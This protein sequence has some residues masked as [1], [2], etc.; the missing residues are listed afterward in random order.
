MKRAIVLAASLLAASCGSSTST[1]PTSTAT[2]T[3][4]TYT[5]TGIVTSTTTGAAIVGASVTVAGGAN[6]G[7]TTTTD[8]GGNYSLAGLAASVFTVDVSATDY[9]PVAD[10]VTLTANQT[11]NVPLSPTPLF[12]MRGEGNATFNMPTAVSKVHITGAYLGVTSSFVVTIGGKVVV[13]DLV[14]SQWTP[15][16]SDGTYATTGGTVAI[17]NSTDVTWTFTEVR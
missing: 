8:S 7:L 10:P 2:T 6:P 1:T 16:V 14:G 4:T 12:V 17:T 3:T 9:N 5:L 15:A 11:L 13:N